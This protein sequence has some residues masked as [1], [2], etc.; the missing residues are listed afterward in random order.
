M[1]V[2]GKMQWLWCAWVLACVGTL[3]GCA[4]G[5]PTVYDPQWDAIQARGVLRVGVPGDYAPYAVREAAA[6]GVTLEMGADVEL[7]RQLAL[8]L[9]LRAEFVPTSWRALVDDATADRFDVAVGGISITPERARQ[10]LFSKPYATDFKQPVARC[11]EQQRFDSLREINLPD[12]RVIVNPGG[13]NERFARENFTHSQLTVHADNLTVF[14]EILAGRA[15]VM[16]TDSVEARIQQRQRLGL[17]A[18]TVRERWAKADKAVLVASSRPLQQQIDTQLRRPAVLAE[19]A[20]TLAQWELVDAAGVRSPDVELALL[21]DARL[22]LVLEVA[23]N[24]WNSGAAIEDL[25]REQALLAGLRERG[26]AL[27]LSSGQVE[28]F[29]GAQI[30]AA[31][32]LQRELFARWKQAHRGR[33]SGVQDLSSDIRPAIDAVTTRMLE[34]LARRQTAAGALPE[35]STMKRIS[36]AAVAAA[37]QPLLKAGT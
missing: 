32:L 3:T 30:E 11:G 1:L 37:R 34:V 12:V 18:V 35:A 15:D 22:A 28:R 24:K 9:G 36:P 26:A 5:A 13:T 29:F 27:G 19:H 21:I 17:C 10:V 2:R 20:R 31:K 7:A 33:F 8:A 16:V 4:T 23:R 6:G 14:D 25:P